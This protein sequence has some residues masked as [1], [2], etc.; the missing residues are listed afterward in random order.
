MPGI[1]FGR[2]SLC[3][4]SRLPIFPTLKKINKKDERAGYF[5]AFKKENMRA[6]GSKSDEQRG[7]TT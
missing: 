2:R 5:H 7:N 1:I 6:R 4:K 3:H